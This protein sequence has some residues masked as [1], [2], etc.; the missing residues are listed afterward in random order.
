M[1]NLLR[2][3][4]SLSFIN[5][6]ISGCDLDQPHK[7][8]MNT[9]DMWFPASHL[10]HPQAALETEV[11]GMWCSGTV[12]QAGVWDCV[13]VCVRVRTWVCVFAVSQSYRF[14]KCRQASEA[15]G[16]GM[17]CWCQSQAISIKP[18]AHSRWHIH[19]THD[20]ILDMV[21]RHDSSTW[22]YASWHV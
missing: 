4:L 9:A 19:F 22:T 5:Y 8:L 6:W 21:T 11:Y 14:R 2:S 10:A 12:L 17:E 13:C 1:T 3:S 20:Y 16:T 18:V 15:D 7:H